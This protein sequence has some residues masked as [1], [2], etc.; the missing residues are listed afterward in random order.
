MDIVTY[1]ILRNGLYATAREMKIAMMRTAG[2]PIVHSGGDASAAVF[3]AECQLVAQGN[4]IPT[5]LGSAVIS[6]KASVDAIGRDRLRPGDVI[7]SNDAYLGGGNHQ[8]D[9]QFT[10]PVFV[11]GEIVAFVMTRGHWTDIGG[12]APGSY[13][14]MTWDIFAE[15]IRIPPVLLYRDE[16]PVQDVLTL[17]VQNTRETEVRMLDIQ[18]QYAGC[19]VGDRRIASMVRKYGKDALKQAMARALDHSERLMREAI[20]A[21][22]DGVYEAEDRLEPVAGPPGWPTAEIPLKVRII[23]QGD[24]IHFDYAGTGSQTRG[25]I[26]CPFSVTCNSTWFTVKAITDVS[27]PINQGCYRPVSIAAPEGSIVNA[28]FPASVVAG[29]TETSPRIIDM[30]LRALAPAVPKRVVGQSNGGANSG[31]FGGMDPDEARVARTRRRYVGTVEPHAGGMGAR[32]DKDGVNGVRV[33]VGNAG[34]TAVEITEQTTPLL[35]QE[36]S[37]VPDSGGAGEYRGGLTSRRVYRVGYEEATY[38]VCGERGIHPPLGQFGGLAGSM[39]HS[40]VRRGD[41]S[42]AKVPAKGSVEIVTKG[43]VVVLQ[44]PGSGGYGDPHR[45]D[46]ARLLEDLRDGYVTGAA[47][48]DYGLSPAEAEALL[49]EAAHG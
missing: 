47:L 46:R 29:N 43:D 39:F 1:E 25:G 37:L 10:R 6:T 31:V 28:R 48:S 13:T 27:I 23:K 41:G 17:I 45:R 2:S 19:F 49:A 11:E 24:G 3:D 33:Y 15:G 9:I 18:A 7:I 20:R 4:D 38:T 12:Q 5:M 36:W 42:V 30:L 21:I 16:T 34:S 14:C 22:P 40:E 32:A 8:P 44:P 26:N 35:V